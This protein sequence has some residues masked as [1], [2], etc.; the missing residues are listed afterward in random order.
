MERKK[1]LLAAFGAGLSWG[2]TSPI[3]QYLFD[4]KGIVSQWLVPARMVLAGVL[5]LL[6]AGFIKKQNLLSVFREKKDILRLLAVGILGMMGMQYSFFAAIQETNA[7]VATIFQY[8]NPAFLLL[9]YAVIYRVLPSKKEIFAVAC[10]VIGIF[11]VATQGNIH[12][13]S[14]SM[15]GFVYGM[16]LAIATC[17]YGVLP[18]PLLKKY[19]AETV[20]GWAM[21]V[22]G[23]VLSLI[24][25]PW[26]IQVHMDTTVG[27]GYLVIT[28]VGTILPFILYLTAVKYVGGVYAG[29]LSSVEPVAAT[30]VAAVFLGTAFPVIDILG[31]ALVLSTLFILN[32]GDHSE[33]R[34][35]SE[36]DESRKVDA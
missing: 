9:F 36:R 6:Y 1:G 27:I 32:I 10:S 13:L 16:A 30:I 24:F 5:L 17:F 28:I 18:G 23:I 11:L 22:G 8:L 2:C 7:G 26:N 25:R 33:T 21:L 14:I 31:F 3:A 34:E 4:N 35:S 12:E 29:L 15:M 19:P 20:C